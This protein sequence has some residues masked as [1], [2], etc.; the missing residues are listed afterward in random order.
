MEIFED[1]FQKLIM[2]TTSL[3]EKQKEAFEFMKNKIN[4]FITG[5]AGCGK[6]FLVKQYKKVFG[7][8]RKIGITSTTGTSALLINGTTL[9]S[10]LGIGLGN[11][12]V[13]A[14]A[15][16]IFCKPYL[17]KRWL[18]LESLIIDEISMLTPEL[19][20]KLENVARII[21]GNDFPFGGIHLILTGDGLQL[22][23]VDSEKMFFEASSWN[24]CIRKIVYLKEIV[25]QKDVEFQKCLNEVRVGNLSLE[26][27]KMLNSRIGIKLH[28]DYNIKP[29]RMFPTNKNVD[30]INAFELD[31]LANDVNH[32]YEYNMEFTFFKK[33]K[34][35]EK[36]RMINKFKKN[37]IVPEVLQL[38]KGVQVM[39]L[40]NIDIEAGLANGSRGI[41]IH[42][43]DDMPVVRFISGIER[44]ITHESWIYEEN[45]KEVMTIEQIPLKIAFAFSIHKAQGITLDYAEIDL[46]NIFEYGQAYVALSRIKNLDGLSITNLDIHKIQ[47]H[48]KALEFYQNLEEIEIEKETSDATHI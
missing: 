25:R 32:I 17:K 10:F 38:C 5:S 42:F 40:K 8:T 1:Q 46:E 13:N 9:H 26:S 48:P 39:L 12:S 14:L 27:E 36:E 35:E 47:A 33:P 3:N 31:K 37:S 29:T 11:K 24:T 16:G 15:S 28:N 30:K 21:R 44:C 23:C 18:E 4:I 20:D 43:L 41:V 6:T 22:P 2:N 19:F 7:M 45:E 34:N